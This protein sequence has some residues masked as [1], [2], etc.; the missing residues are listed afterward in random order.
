MLGYSSAKRPR[1]LTNHLAAKSGDVLTVSAP[2]LWRWSSRSVPSAMRSKASRRMVR[3]WRPASVMTRRWRSRLKSLT[4]SS[5]S[6]ALTWWLT[7]PWVT[8]SSS[9]ARVKL[10]W[11]AA[12][13]KAFNALSEGRRRSIFRPHEKNSGRVEKRCFAGNSLLVLLVY[14][15]RI[16][17]IQFGAPQMSTH[18]AKA[19]G[20]RRYGA[21]PATRSTL[22]KILSTL[23][24][25]FARSVQRR[26]L[27]DLA[28]D[29]R[30]LNDIGLDQ[31]EA[32]R[33]AAKPFWRQ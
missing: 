16:E 12:A 11:R 17:R 21:R 7:A 6:K 10:S 30:L 33:E 24:I 25:W 2:E 3:Y 27:R 29:V 28:R 22:S 32:L 26:A 8:N 4:P 19:L 31:Q 5:N 23:G 14:S 1:R 13:S 20:V 15:I 18:P 9:A